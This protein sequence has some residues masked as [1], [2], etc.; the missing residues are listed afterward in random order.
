MHL[1]H[2]LHGLSDRDSA[3]LTYCIFLCYFVTTKLF[4]NLQTDTA[5]RSRTHPF[6]AEVDGALAQRPVETVRA[7]A[8][9][10]ARVRD[11]LLAVRT[12][13]G[14]AR[15]HTRDTCSQKGVVDATHTECTTWQLA[16]PGRHIFLAALDDG[17]SDFGNLWFTSVS[18]KKHSPRGQT[19][20]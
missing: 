20:L 14:C 6:G 3:M 11:A 17:L 10:P 4:C 2:A 5:T 15:I 13:G 16:I 7:C 9:E 19:Q 8:R 12:G 18:H 1:L